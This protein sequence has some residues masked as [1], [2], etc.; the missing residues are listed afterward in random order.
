MKILHVVTGLT[1]A[2]GV[3]VFVG[4]LAAEQVVQGHEVTILLKHLGDDVY[5]V[6][7]GVV[8]S[9]TVEVSGF[10]IVH[11]HALWDPWL[12]RMA[13]RAKR[14]GAKVVWSPHGMLTPWALKNKWPKKVLG[15]V[16]YQ[17][18]ALRKADLIHVTAESEA[19]DVRRLRL[20][21][22]LVI[23]PLGVRLFAACAE[24]VKTS[25][26]TRNKTLLFVSRVQRKKG[27]PNL[28]DAWAIVPP[29]VRKGW[30]IVI[31]GPD[32]DNHTAE[33][34]AQGRRLGIDSD[35]RFLGPVYGEAKTQL[36]RS[37]DLFVLPTY[38]ENF[39]SVV[40]EALAEEVPVICTKGAPWH[41]LLG[42]GEGTDAVSR[43]A[44]G[45]RCGWW[46]EIGVEPLALALR[47]AM[48]LDDETRRTMGQNGRRLVETKYTWSAVA[49]TLEK[50]Y[51]E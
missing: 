11:L 23:A 27:L 14:A 47:E 21:K 31:A 20:G 19:Q 51:Q 13:K 6:K 43:M 1:R 45:G 36:Y 49:S 10:D 7:D 5:P 48:S 30:Q 29:T 9:T 39:G 18:W 33:L 24:S 25:P 4:E 15:L 44:C 37:A 2:N 28:L 40:V 50:A 26:L 34:K 16:L 17:Y 32:Q 46:V 12:T 3:S 38:S 35:V 8:L 42:T 22:R 41:E